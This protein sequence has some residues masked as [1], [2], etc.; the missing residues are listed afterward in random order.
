MTILIVLTRLH[1][2]L[3]RLDHANWQHS[4]PDHTASTLRSKDTTNNKAQNV[5]STLDTIFDIMEG[6]VKLCD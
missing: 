4:L 6:T 1:A 2:F 3:H 5:Y